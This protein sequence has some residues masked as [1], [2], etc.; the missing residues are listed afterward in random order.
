M[1]D[2]YLFIFYLNNIYSLHLFQKNIA[3]LGGN[4]C[5]FKLIS[6]FLKRKKVKGG[7]WHTQN[8][9]TIDWKII[10]F[11]NKILNFTKQRTINVM[12]YVK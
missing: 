8:L 7:Q 11:D 9:V 10:S 12:V 5:N 1:V 4:V 3:Y 6:F 2:Y